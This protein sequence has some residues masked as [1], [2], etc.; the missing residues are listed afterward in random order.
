MRK[1]AQNKPFIIAAGLALVFVGL[2]VVACIFYRSWSAEGLSGMTK[3]LGN[4]ALRQAAR[5]EAVGDYEGAIQHYQAALDGHLPGGRDR[6]HAEKRMG[7]VLW[8]Q[9]NYAEAAAHFQRAQ[10]S[11]F[12]SLNGY[13]HW[14]DA[15]EKL[16]RWE[17]ADVVANT[18]LEACI[19][20][21][22]L[23]VIRA[24]ALLALGQQ[25]RH[26]GDRVLARN[27]YTRAL[28]L[29]RDHE[30]QVAL[31]TLIYEDGKPEIAE[32]ILVTYLRDA[33]AGPVA[34]KALALLRVWMS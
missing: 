5:S 31:A 21:G 34:D 25:A 32:A 10:E 16:G 4:V 33:P 8:V 7:I 11:P 13:K 23:G 19:E 15:L 24:D 29:V 2:F 3:D 18:W 14:V 12:R 20:G 9:G 26:H 30:A 22:N 28:N 27:F 17:E 6:V 1:S